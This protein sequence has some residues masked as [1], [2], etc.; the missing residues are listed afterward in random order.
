MQA[1]DGENVSYFEVY[2]DVTDVEETGKVTWVV[3]PAGDTD[4]VPA[5]VV[6]RQFQPGASLTASLTDPDDVA[7]GEAQDDY[8]YYVEVVPVVDRD[9]PA[10]ATD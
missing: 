4:Q 3:D 5:G 8:W 2:V 10:L 6:L 9:K 1:S 7:D